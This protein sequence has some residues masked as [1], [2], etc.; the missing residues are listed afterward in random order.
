MKDKLKPSWETYSRIIWDEQYNENNFMVGYQDRVAPSGRRE[1]P[2]IEWDSS[3]IPWN[4]VQYFR[5]G[6]TLVWDRQEQVDLM[7]T[8]QLPPEAYH[9]V[10][11]KKAANYSIQHSPFKA[12]PIVHYKNKEWQY[13]M[14]DHKSV[15]H[16]NLKIA[17]YNICLLYTS[18]SPRD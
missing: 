4:R 13:Y 16:S 7:G 6:E 10:A 1:K 17:T 11:D 3:D 15:P 12:K 8:N 18:P 14:E 5:C 9:P 2:I